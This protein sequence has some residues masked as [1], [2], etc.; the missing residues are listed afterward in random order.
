MFYY[1]I[2]IRLCIHNIKPNIKCQ[3]YLQYKCEKYLYNIADSAAEKQ[4]INTICN[5][6]L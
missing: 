5:K 2:F 4:K 3:H 6:Y 1:I